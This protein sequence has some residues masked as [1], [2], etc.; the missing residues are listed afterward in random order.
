MIFYIN[1]I[2]KLRRAKF[3][4][5][6][7]ILFNSLVLFYVDLKFNVFYFLCFLCFFYKKH[8]KHKSAVNK[9]IKIKVFNS[10]IR[11]FKFS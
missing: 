8:R 7:F 1:S 11:F 9:P 10:V 2:K 4:I 3:Y 5:K 6:K